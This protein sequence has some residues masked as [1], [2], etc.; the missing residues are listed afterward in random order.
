MGQ[1]MVCQIVVN[2]IRKRPVILASSFPP[3]VL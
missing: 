3:F 2:D 1:N